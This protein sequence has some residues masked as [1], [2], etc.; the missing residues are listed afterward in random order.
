MTIEIE[1]HLTNNGKMMIVEYF[2]MYIPVCLFLQGARGIV[3]L[4]IMKVSIDLGL[5]EAR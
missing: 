1:T 4:L 3:K 5:F 2:F